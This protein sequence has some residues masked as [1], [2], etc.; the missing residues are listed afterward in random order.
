MS[1]VVGK[2]PSFLLPKH[3]YFGPGNQSRAEGNP[4]EPVDEDDRIA[5]RHD[6]A[7]YRAQTKEDIYSADR[8]AIGEFSKD[9]FTT[10][11]WHS[12]LGAAG[13]GLKHGFEKLTGSV[14]YPNLGEYGQ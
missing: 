5:S 1:S 7:Y 9:F 8:T 10:G 6:D 11:N 14:V 4:L 13:I 3:N 2:K 12:G